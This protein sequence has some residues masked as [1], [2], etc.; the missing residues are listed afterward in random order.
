M[1]GRLD[2]LAFLQESAARMRQI[3][4]EHKQ[5]RIAGELR[6]IADEI[7]HQA[8]ELEA[9]LI[10]AGLLDAGLGPGPMRKS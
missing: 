7:A 5:L 9:E 4:V 6:V 3:T 1:P 8:V 10:E 2:V